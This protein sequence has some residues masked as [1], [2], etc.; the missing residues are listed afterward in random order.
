MKRYNLKSIMHNAW[1]YKRSLAKKGIVKSIGYCL[2]KAWTDA[3][4]LVKELAEKAISEPV[5]TWY[6]W[7]QLGRE[8]M[9]DHKCVI[10]IVVEDLT[11]KAG[12]TVKS[13][14]LLSDTCVLGTQE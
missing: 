7:T 10:Q 14:F 6:G 3:K 1:S 12:H 4:A 13:Y 11:K 8:V 9:H 5:A 2:K